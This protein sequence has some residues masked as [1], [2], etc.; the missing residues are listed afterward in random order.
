LIGI[1]LLGAA[2]IYFAWVAAKQRQIRFQGWKLSL[3][4]WRVTIGQMGLGVADVCAG[5]AVLYVLLPQ[6][7][8]HSFEAFLAVYVL[9]HMLG[10]ASHVPGGVGAFEATILIALR[11]S[12]SQG[13]LLS[14]LLLYRCIYYL[15]PFVIAL[16]MLALGE[17]VRR[18]RAIRATM[19]TGE[20][21]EVHPP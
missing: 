18:A 5:G 11:G 15:I 13:E 16:T 4:N 9:G 19:G 6:G 7:H 8:G 12:A 1:A 17:V 21:E 10:V 3:P 2:L 14:T 20:E